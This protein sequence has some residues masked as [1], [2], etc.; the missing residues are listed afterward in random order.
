MSADRPRRGF[1]LIEL[2]VVIAIIAVLIALLLPAVQAA[3]E[4]ARRS[5]CTNNLKQI[6]LGLHNYI[7]IYDSLPPGALSNRIPGTLAIDWV[8]HGPGIFLF[9]L[10]QV[11]QQQMFNAFNFQTGCIAGCSDNTQELTVINTKILTF[12]CPS[13]PNA[14]VWPAGTNYGGSIGAQFR[15]GDADA[16]DGNIGPFVTNRSI[17][18]A[19]V[20]DGTSN[21][22]AFLEKIQSDGNPNQVTGGELYTNLQ[23]PSGTGGGYGLGPDQYMGSGQ[24]YL[25]KYVALC[26]P[27][28]AAGQNLIDQQS[29]WAAGRCYHGTCVNMLM[30][31]N[32]SMTG[33][34]GMY[35][36]SGAMFSSRS[37]H[38]GGVNTAMCDGSV[39]FVKNSVNSAVWWALGSRGFGEVVSSDSF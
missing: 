22:V 24:Q 39:R 35:Q 7:S 34:C 28:K 3:R 11:E 17:K 30:T 18:L 38:A 13:D 5:Q 10:A 36:A 4:A 19:E 27:Y 2:L 15:W 8:A 1:T 12:I 29:I 26:G 21:T 32:W 23:W 6:G 33:D 31:P 16:T 14:G 20:T 9:M 25:Q 37:R